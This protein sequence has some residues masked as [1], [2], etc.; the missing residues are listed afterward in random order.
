LEKVADFAY[1]GILPEAAVFDNSSRY[2]AVANYDHFDD[3]KVGGSIDFWR[4]E[5]DP[6]DASTTHL[7]KT[8]RSIPVTRG[9]HSMAI[10]R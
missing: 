9:V 5:T 8:E 7:V 3:R 2:I 1:D 10:A 6:L 4:I